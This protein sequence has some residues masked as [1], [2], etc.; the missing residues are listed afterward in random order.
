MKRKNKFICLCGHEEEI[1]NFDPDS[2][3]FGC[4]HKFF[5][6]IAPSYDMEPDPLNPKYCMCREFRPDTLKYVEDHCER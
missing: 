2:I 6:S 4:T 5:S 3:F 1:H